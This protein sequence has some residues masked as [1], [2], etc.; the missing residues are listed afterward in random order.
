MKKTFKTACLLLELTVL[1]VLV[2]M[3]FHCRAQ[4]ERS[5][6]NIET[7][8]RLYGYVRYFHPSDEAAQTDWNRYAIYGVK[9]ASA[10]QNPE[11][12]KRILEELFQPIAPTLVLYRNN[13]QK[14]VTHSTLHPAEPTGQEVIAW[15]HRGVK[16]PDSP[17]VFDSIRV[18]GSK[19]LYPQLPAIG[20][21]I[22]KDIGNGLS[23][24]LPLALYCTR[25]HTY[26]TPPPNAFET[27]QTAIAREV[28][29]YPRAADPAVRQAGIVITWTA[30]QHFYP[31]FD[32]AEV[33]WD[34][35]LT[36]AL[37]RAQ[38][39]KTETEFLNTLRDLLE[40]L[41]DC[42]AAVYHP[43]LNDQA[44][45][46]IKT[47]WAEHLAVIAATRD[48]SFHRGDIILAIDGKKVD[49]LL[50]ER[51]KT[52]SGTPQWKRHQAINLLGSGTKG[53]N[54]R[55]EL[56]REG[57]VIEITTPR[58]FKG[59]VREFYYPPIRELKNNIYYINLE[60]ITPTQFE[61]NRQQLADARG[62][63]FDARGNV[64]YEKR[65]I[66][67]ALVDHPIKTPYYRY[68]EIIYPDREKARYTDYAWNT[69]PKAPRIT[70]TCV[71]LVDTGAINATETFMGMVEYY[72]LGEIVGQATAG[73]NGNINVLRLPGAYMVFFTGMRVEKQDHTQHHLIGIKPTVAVERTVA[74][75][76][77]GRDEILEKAMEIILNKKLT[78]N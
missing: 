59:Q 4:D 26:P 51:E 27:L 13:E 66:L 72:R 69:V 52:I 63:I 25:Y 44:W 64:A 36:R 2:A 18:T 45:L 58:D 73:T 1:T 62:V 43:V 9:R 67:G 15:Q 10:A 29:P 12:L 53:T 24:N 41:K 47:V 11:E 23:C 39:D 37:R 78:N 50:R 3:V 57:K 22:N 8:A 35:R 75:I 21:H 54:A 19:R 28:P 46:P 68:P 77:Q 31:Y 70:A 6:K 42:N 74:G 33:N 5:I 60:H 34:H 49:K 38:T 20:E 14:T 61:A 40:P 56:L 48:K 16:F 7:F 76:K 55:L 71:F 17:D 32:L 65:H 30:M